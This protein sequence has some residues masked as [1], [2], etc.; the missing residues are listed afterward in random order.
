MLRRGPVYV[1]NEVFFLGKKTDSPKHLFQSPYA[2]KRASLL[3]LVQVQ[4]LKA[5]DELCHCKCR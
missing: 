5:F 3:S 4:V 1:M 2:T